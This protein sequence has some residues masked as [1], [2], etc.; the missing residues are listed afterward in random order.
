[1]GSDR[2]LLAAY[3]L[4]TIAFMQVTSL[5][6]HWIWAAIAAPS[7]TLSFAVSLYPKTR[8]FAP[9]LAVAGSVIIP[10]VYLVMNGMAQ[11]EVAVIVDG[12]RRFIAHGTPYLSDP[13]SL[14]AMT[15][16][17]P[18]M[19]LFGMPRALGLSGPLGDPRLWIGATFI[20][21]LVWV[22][23]DR[24]SEAITDHKVQRSSLALFLCFPL[25]ALT[26]CVSAIDIPMCAASL[27]ALACYRKQQFVATGFLSGLAL[28]MKPTALF[29]VVALAAAMTRKR[30]R[31]GS[32][33]YLV[34]VALTF[35]AAVLPPLLLDAR[36]M[37]VNTVAFPAGSTSIPSPALSPLPGVLLAQHLI[38]GPTIARAMVLVVIGSGCVFIWRSAPQT[39]A[40]ISRQT[41]VAL[42]VAICVAPNS[43]VGY[44]VFPLTLW[45][46][47]SRSNIWSPILTGDVRWKA[48]G[49]DG[50]SGSAEPP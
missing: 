20:G 8:R 10:L 35:G 19:F 21:V 6:P 9:Y 11:P 40:G 4:M 34:S 30:P 7:Y 38:S 45:A 50:P 47:G 28:A 5:A 39:T 33:L 22:T 32:K 44:F 27:L 16:Y 43:R 41:A 49:S 12:A 15:P 3:A 1:V 23:T 29:L 36:A 37:W 42:S 2:A 26:L 13:V 18:A 48:N 24:P 25:V 17:L 31:T 46:M 14:D